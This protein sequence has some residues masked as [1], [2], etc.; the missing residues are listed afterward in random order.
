VLAIGLLCSWLAVSGTAAEDLPRWLVGHWTGAREGQ[1]SSSLDWV[2]RGTTLEGTLEVTYPHGRK[3]QRRFSIAPHASDLPQFRFYTLELH[4][5]AGPEQ[6]WFAGYQNRS[7][8]DFLRFDRR[9][10]SR[11]IN[12]SSYIAIVEM[13]F[14]NAELDITEML[15]PQHGKMVERQFAF[16]RAE[17]KSQ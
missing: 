15:G 9:L 14:L 2:D 10:K 6:Y 17:P 1:E 11:G 12:R 7:E 8:Y 5:T 3:E 16:R 4:V 13:H